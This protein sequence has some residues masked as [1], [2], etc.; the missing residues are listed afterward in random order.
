MLALVLAHEE[1][2]AGASEIFAELDGNTSIYDYNDPFI[3]VEF[4]HLIWFDWGNVETAQGNLIHAIEL[5]TRA[6]EETSEEWFPPFVGRGNAAMLQGD[7]EMA[8]ADLEHALAMAEDLP[9]SKAMIEALLTE[10]AEQESLVE[11]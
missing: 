3:N 10:L 4:G 11:Q 5:Y 6:I 8:R 7:F 9:E 1:D 2:Y